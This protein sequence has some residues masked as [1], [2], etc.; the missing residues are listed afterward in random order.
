MASMTTLR[1]EKA[2]GPVSINMPKLKWEY[3]I[4]EQ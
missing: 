4:S 2:L 1:T 3:D